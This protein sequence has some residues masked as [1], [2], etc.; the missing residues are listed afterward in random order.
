MAAEGIVFHREGTD[1]MCKLIR[2]MFDWLV[3]KRHKEDLKERI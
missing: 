2:D 3:G 1:E